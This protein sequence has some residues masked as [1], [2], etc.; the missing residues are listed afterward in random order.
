MASFT[1]K[2]HLHRFVAKLDISDMPSTWLK[3]MNSMICKCRVHKRRGSYK[4]LKY[5]DVCK[6]LD[7]LKGQFF[8]VCR[9]VLFSLLKEYVTQYS[10]QYSRMK[11]NENSKWVCSSTGSCL[12]SRLTCRAT[13]PALPN[14]LIWLHWSWI[15]LH[16]TFSKKHSNNS[17]PL[18]S[19]K[20]IPC[21]KLLN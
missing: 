13:S 16:H 19:Q 5:Q 14:S 6:P 11:V 4:Y 9:I 21:C 20:I 3:N 8:C 10:S 18:S 15:L 7:I 12:G 2:I 17:S 1:V